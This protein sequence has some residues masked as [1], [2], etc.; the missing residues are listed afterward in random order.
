MK[1]KFFIQKLE[2]TI[3]QPQTGE[4]LT[5]IDDMLACFREF[6]TICEKY[7]YKAMV[8]GADMVSNGALKPVVE[9][10]ESILSKRFG[11]TYHITIDQDVCLGNAYAIPVWPYLD[12]IDLECKNFYKS[13]NENIKMLKEEIKNG[14]DTLTDRNELKNYEKIL[15]NGEIINKK[16]KNGLLKI[17]TANVR[18]INCE[19]LNVYVGIDLINFLIMPQYGLTEREAL[20]ILLHEIGHT[21]EFIYGLNSELILNNN[22]YDEIE[23]IASKG[24]KIKDI[25]KVIV[26]SKDGKVIGGENLDKTNE[27]VIMA[28]CFK[29]VLNREEKHGW[30]KNR[31]LNQ[32]LEA[33]KFASLFH[34]GVDVIT[35]LQK[36]RK[37][38]FYSSTQDVYSGLGRYL[39]SF[40]LIRLLLLLTKWF[41]ILLITVFGVMVTLMGCGLFIGAFLTMVLY[42]AV[43]WVLN[44]VFYFQKAGVK[45]LL[46]YRGFKDR[47]QH[48]KNE[49]VKQ[50]KRIDKKKHPE[51]HQHLLKQIQMCE[52][53]IGDTSKLWE[54]IPKSFYIPGEFLTCLL[55]YIIPGRKTANELYNLE[56][57]ME[58]MVNNTLHVGSAKLRDAINK[59]DG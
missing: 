30:Y 35:G 10:M 54:G 44:S 38:N 43:K 6:K 9:R 1:N 34:L 13:V 57:R 32:E 5:F 51:L 22:L 59:K 26:R 2:A 39:V 16:I 29:E 55:T 24:G 11:A 3:F 17:D 15:K 56:L 46:E 48:L 20:G 18:F 21:F 47:A 58:D 28:K 8:N 52:D 49:T 41:S 45:E 25:A 37:Y 36:M 33:D 53:V 4:N 19:D 7:R 40:S 50:L 14:E 27:V 31:R 42:Y 12:T 23:H